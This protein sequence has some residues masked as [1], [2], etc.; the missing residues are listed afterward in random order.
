MSSIYMLRMGEPHPRAITRAARR[1]ALV[2]PAVARRMTKRG[3]A[4][5]GLNEY[6]FCAFQDDA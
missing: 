3:S 1:V 5:L 4:C 2:V 6:V